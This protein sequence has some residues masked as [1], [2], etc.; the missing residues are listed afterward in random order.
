MWG[1]LTLF[2]TWIIQILVML[3]A[4]IGYLPLVASLILVALIIIPMRSKWANSKWA[5]LVLGKSYI[6][7]LA[8]YYQKQKYS[9][10]FWLN[11]I[12][13]NTFLLAGAILIILK[14]NFR[15][16]DLF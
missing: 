3:Y 5:E 2:V 15:V 9:K 4:G 6:T 10:L 16:I 7:N 8:P 13:I 1:I 11:F 12:V 14:F